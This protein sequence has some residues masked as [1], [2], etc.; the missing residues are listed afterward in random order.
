MITMRKK[1]KSALSKI[2]VL[3][4]LLSALFA[5]FLSSAQTTNAEAPKIIT[6]PEWG[7]DESK[8][9]WP[10]KYAKV[11]KIVIHHTASSNLVPDP[12]GSG[13]Y[14]N[15]VN[16]IY[17]YHNSK[18]TWYDDNGEYTGFGDIGYNYLIDPNGNIYEGRF[19]G[20]GVVAGHVNGFNAGS[21]GI[22]VLGRYQDYFDSSN[23][24][25][26][27]H[28]VTPAIKES[29]ENLVGWI[30]ANNNIDLNKV[31]D[32]YGKNIDGLVGHKDLRPTI[33]P[34]DGLYKQI[35]IIQTNAGNLVKQ[36]KNYAYQIG[37]DTAVYI[38]EDGYKTK[39]DSKD[40]LPSAY[41]DRIIKPIL[42]NQLDMYKYKN[43]VIYPDGS[44]LQEFDTAKVFYLE[45]GQKRA[46]EM[47]GEEFVKM[48]F[49]VSDIKKVFS[50]DLKIYEN[51]KIIKYAPDGQLIKD[52]NGN[53]FL[54]ENGKKRKFTSAQ[55]FEYLNYKWKNIKEDAYL[56]FYL[57]G[58]DMIYPD[59][60]LA[61]QT[62]KNEI[63][64]IE[65]KQRREITSSKL[66]GV[67]KYNPA[68]VI[69][70]TEN[71]LN[72]FPA[73][74]KM[75]YPDSA[76]VKAE[77][78]PS[79]Y[80][81]QNGKR[82]EFTSA[83]LFEK[84]GYKW[85]N[86]INIT[87]SEMENHPA[88]GKVLY[89]N[90]YLIKS[91]DNPA[92]YILEAGKKRIVTSAVLFEKR[93]YKW[94]EIV[95][96][97]PEEIKDYPD[98][99]IMTYPDRTLIRR[100]GFPVIY[101]IED[102]TK[103]EFT[104]LALFEATKSKW[105][106]VI[107]LNKDEFL[108][109]PDGGVVKYPENTLLKTAGD[110]KIYV[111]KNGI[112]EWIKTME[113]F[114]KAG[115]KWS[116]I[117]EIS[118]AEMN[119]YIAVEN[120]IVNIN[121]PAPQTPPQNN[122]EETNVPSNIN[123]DDTNSSGIN[124]TSENNPN[125]RIALYSSPGED[126]KITANGNY[127]V[128]YYNSSGTINKTENKSANEQAIIPYFSSSDYV[129]FIPEN[130]NVIL[131]VLSYSDLAWDKKTNDNKF[132]G[133]IEIKYSN[134]SQKL[135]I[136]NELPLEDYVNGIAEALN[137]SPEE[138]LKA[139]GTIARTYA[140]SYIKKG[141][142]HIGEPFHLKNSRNGNGNDQVYKGYNFEAR[143][144]KITVANKSTAGYII[145]YNG[146]PIVAAYSS[147]SGGTTK[148]GCK[149]LGYCGDDYAYLKGG[150]NDP[151][152]TKHDQAIVLKSH[153]AGMSAVGAYQMA[154]DGSAWQSIIK[155]YYPGVEVK[156]Y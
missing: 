89:P 19:G 98:G 94:S 72:H 115:Y 105:S 141:G 74:E 130:R 122:A 62:G 135:W 63:Y 124:N 79:V 100:E 116:G 112:A 121:N 128:N 82:K 132:R 102:E 65:N 28:P 147:D 60:I 106:D 108:A 149:I 143:A 68:N 43:I 75:K 57:D 101:R 42:K 110:D 50:S 71:E 146:K 17:S 35:N 120:A 3:Q 131:E 1:I 46:M 54:A 73:G 44:L 76:L 140:M 156:K 30:A 138:Y 33:C 13:E 93:G 52:Q 136:I 25:V 97:N 83:V 26:S 7:A 67:L 153:G 14:K 10:E 23:N 24:T 9:T 4:L 96:L 78:S 154:A 59:G 12:D 2:I 117:I 85:S 5:P 127:A 133:N 47:A 64:L 114:K 134:T 56:S 21:V 155:Y 53:V 32:F 144:P 48:G 151:V 125:I 99:K 87:K 31:T 70:I 80:L 152:N 37:G 8:M 27:S 148:D 15:M 61:K 104:S 137:D 41:K 95:S 86:I 118:K 16:N 55:L 6:R 77:D 88:N 36:Y 11:E 111:M 145:N 91:S 84:L 103:K 107:I 90:G 38:I 92:V 66:M 109:Y 22:S 150:I 45:E 129:K 58:L 39:F 18:K 126:V 113:E 119:L 81:I 139:F 34:G 49:A 69:S 40:V 142:K 51:G 123:S 29:L 20:N